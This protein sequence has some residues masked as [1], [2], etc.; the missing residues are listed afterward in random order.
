VTDLDGGPVDTGAGDTRRGRGGL[1]A[2][3]DT[4]THD[5]MLALMRE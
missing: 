5:A 3:A 1:L 2:A 4:I